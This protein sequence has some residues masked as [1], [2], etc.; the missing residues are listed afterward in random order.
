MSIAMQ[1]PL[2]D[3][4]TDDENNSQR[5]Q[6]K[7]RKRKREP[8][9]EGDVRFAKVVPICGGAFAKKRC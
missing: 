1:P 5:P 3:W 9:D 4:D 8:S 2:Q 6:R 7:K